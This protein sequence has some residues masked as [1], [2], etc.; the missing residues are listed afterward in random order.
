ML[1]VIFN[2]FK[3]ITLFLASACEFSDSSSFCTPLLSSMTNSTQEYM[4]G[5]WRSYWM[6]VFE[7]QRHPPNKLIISVVRNHKEIFHITLN[8]LVAA[9]KC[10]F[11]SFWKLISIDLFWMLISF[12]R[13]HPHFQWTMKNHAV[14][15]EL[16]DCHCFGIEYVLL[17]Y[18]FT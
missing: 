9:N 12:D 8:Y 4:H 5:N 17:T 16:T 11:D 2:L 18:F 10:R 1:R 13:P 14:M 3:S 6:T 7:K 15:V